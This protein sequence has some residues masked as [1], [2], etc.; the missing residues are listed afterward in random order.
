MNVAQAIIKH[1]E[2]EN[3][4]TVFGYPGGAVLTLYDELRK[5]NINHILVR[6]EQSS[7]HYASGYARQSSEVGVCI[8][9]SGPGATNLITGIATAYMDSIPVVILTGQ[10]HSDLIGTDAFQEAD[11]TGATHPFTKHSYLLKKADDIHRVLY[12]AFHI[13]KTGRP[14]PVLIDIPSD[15]FSETI[16]YIDSYEIDI[17]GYKPTTKGHKGQIKRSVA[18]LK[19][20]KKPLIFAGGG[21]LAANASEE[22]RI[23]AEKN[24]IPVVNSLMGIGSFDHDSSLYCGLVGSH[25]HP[26]ANKLFSNAD[27]IMAIGAR[28]SNRAMHRLENLNPDIEIIHIDVDP[29]EI[30]K[31]LEATIP[32]VGDAKLILSEFNKF[33]IN[34]DTS[35]WLREID[36]YKNSDFASPDDSLG[37]V[38]PKNF[39]KKLSSALSDSSVL[40]ADVGQNQFWSTRNYKI[41]G[42]RKFMTSGGLGT[43][44]YSLPAAV[45]AKLADPSKQVISTIGD[46]GFQMCLGELGVIADHNIGVKII[47]FKNSRLG[48]VREL[49]DNTYGDDRNF[50]VTLDFD[51]DFVQLAKAYNI[52]GIR[53]STDDEV[54]EAISRILSDDKPYIVECLVSPKYS[55]L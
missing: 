13:A 53:V 11:I 3:V 18:R 33:D 30:S 51:V 50:G 7:V 5:S 48:M 29:A 26:Y 21:V 24:Q 6:N 23:F 55:T 2:K 45:G 14:G 25:G 9:T 37:L 27:V 35:Q 28:M 49:Q 8:A 42:S 19:D 38:S 22:L 52:E 40:V 32:V 10:V 47:I 17:K 4:T 36:K 43:M 54:D 1:L 16:K 20:S 46:G 12:E 44:G 31:N 41:S 15:V 39:V 34:M